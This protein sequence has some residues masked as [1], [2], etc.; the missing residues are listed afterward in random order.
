MDRLVRIFFAIC[1]FFM[2]P[3]GWIAIWGMYSM[4][5]DRQ[6]AFEVRERRRA[7]AIAAHERR[8]RELLG[9]IRD[10]RRRREQWER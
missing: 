9:A 7:D 4:R 1:W 8:H 3:I 2:G 6:A 5:R 10:G